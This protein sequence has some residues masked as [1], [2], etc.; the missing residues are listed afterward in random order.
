MIPN[1]PKTL[2]PSSGM[3][4]SFTFSKDFEFQSV[5][6]FATPAA[7]AVSPI[8]EPRPHACNTQTQQFL[9]QCAALQPFFSAD[10]RIADAIPRTIQAE[11]ELN[12][13]GNKG[14]CFKDGCSKNLSNDECSRR[15]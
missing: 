13:L 10:P 15:N 4:S 6:P 11:E 2:I 3:A 5:N 14:N 9:C 12:N 1:D 8:C 7:R